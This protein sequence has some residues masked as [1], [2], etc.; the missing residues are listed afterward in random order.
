MKGRRKKKHFEVRYEI[1]GG[2]FHLFAFNTKIG[3][4]SLGFFIYKKKKSL[5][6]SQGCRASCYQYKR[7]SRP[8]GTNKYMVFN[9][10]L[11]ITKSFEDTWG[12]EAQKAEGTYLGSFAHLVEQC[13]TFCFFVFLFLFFQC[14]PLRS[15][16]RQFFPNWPSYPYEILTSQI[17]C[18]S[19]Y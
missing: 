2:P 4:M 9:V 11:T 14:H 8:T 15:L 12:T 19:L 3:Y 18:M 13:S 17:Y 16:F 5:F 1:L 6:I 7:G 10:T